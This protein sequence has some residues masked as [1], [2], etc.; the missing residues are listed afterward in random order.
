[1]NS[2]IW[3]NPNLL[4]ILIMK[5]VPVSLVRIGIDIGGTFT[6]F[7]IALGDHR[8]AG[9][10]QIFTHKEP[11]TPAAPEQAVIKGL[12]QINKRIQ[13]ALGDFGENYRQ[14]IIH[15]STVATNALLERKGARTALIT[16]E[17]FRDV[18]AIGRQNRPHLYNLSADLPPPLV[19]AQWRL[20]VRERVDHR[21]R[22][23]VP[24]AGQRSRR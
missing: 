4:I 22:V 9:R 15:G 19:P 23:L 10:P 16:T 20:E 17:G 11:S 2:N 6:D 3:I 21:G 1:M 13:S 18:L 8:R 12:G 24:L 5:H 14:Q 7:V